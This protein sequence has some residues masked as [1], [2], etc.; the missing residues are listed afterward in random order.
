M[1]TIISPPVFA[2]TW[3]LAMIITM[4]LGRR[5]G[6]RQNEKEPGKEMAGID[7]MGGTVFTL[8]GLLIAFTLTGAASR[9]DERRMLIADEANEIGTAYLRI[10]LLP[11]SS[12]PELRQLFYDYVESRLEVYR[13]LPD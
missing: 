7:M 12:Q 10:D 13:K 3:L 1:D 2:G 6:V 4:E 5:V 8:C 9:Y 11:D